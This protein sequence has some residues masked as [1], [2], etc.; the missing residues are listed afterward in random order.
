MLYAKLLTASLN[1][2]ANKQLLDWKLSRV[3][4]SDVELITASL[5]RV[6]V[7]FCCL[8]LQG[9]NCCS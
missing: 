6:I 9:E 2:F 8:S 7:A 3:F 4:I 5:D 1:K